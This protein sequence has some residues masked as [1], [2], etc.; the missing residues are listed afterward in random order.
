MIGQWPAKKIQQH[1]R[2][3]ESVSVP[4]VR[5]ACRGDAMA[6]TQRQFQFR[7]LSGDPRF[8]VQLDDILTPHTASANPR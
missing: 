4:R 6:V 5:L 8:S 3:A 1:G 7:T 2:A